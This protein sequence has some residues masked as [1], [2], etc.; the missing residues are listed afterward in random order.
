MEALDEFTEPCPVVQVQPQPQQATPDRPPKNKPK[1]EKP[2]IPQDSQNVAETEKLDPNKDNK[3]SISGD[4]L[5][6]L[7]QIG[8]GEFAEIYKGIFY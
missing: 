4:R 5:H 7:E 6:K 3:Y 1:K 8:D 2:P